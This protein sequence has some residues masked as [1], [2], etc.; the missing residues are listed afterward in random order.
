MCN[1]IGSYG[2]G[3]LGVRFSRKRLLAAIYA[4]RT[5]TIAVHVSLPVS[6]AS[7]L[8]F[9]A[10]MG[11][12]WLGVVPLVSG[13]IGRLFGLGNFNVLFGLAFFCHQFG[14]FLGP[15]TG[16]WSSTAPAAISWRGMR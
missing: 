5:V 12:T 6:P 4:I 3:L 2:F 1:A 13:L 9:A 8:V 14:G 15:L 16:A 10:V 7:T 11:F